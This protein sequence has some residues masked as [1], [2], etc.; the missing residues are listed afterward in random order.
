MKLHHMTRLMSAGLLAGALALGAAL[1]WP[2]WIWFL[3]PALAAGA[4]LADMRVSSAEGGS[5]PFPEEDE[6][7]AAEPPPEAPYSDTS[8]VVVPVQSAL[9]DCPFLFSATIWWREA[10]G[11]ISLPHGNPA[12][13]A[14]TSILQRVQHV[15][16]AEHPVRCTFL[17]HWLE[18]VLGTPTT[19][20]SGT[21]TSYATDVRLVLRQGDQEHLD[22][23]DGL[24]K[25]MGTWESRRQHE[26]NLR[27]YLGE[28]VL[29]SPGSAVVW[30]MAR[31]DDEI[32]RA[33]EMIAPL[34]VLS[35]AA[36]DQEI[37]DKFFDLFVSRDDSAGSEPAGGF[38]HPEPLDD[39]IPPREET[40]TRSEGYSP[41]PGERASALL[42]EM[43]FPQGS[44]ERAAFVHR[45]ARMSDEAGRSDAAE[46]I[47]RVLRREE[48][49]A[50]GSHEEWV[51]GSTSVPDAG[52]PP[53]SGDEASAAH[54]DS[55]HRAD[56]VGESRPGGWQVTPT[57]EVSEAETPDRSGSCDSVQ[58]RPEDGDEGVER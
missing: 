5:S 13:L 48:N 21:V 47:R 23:L 16:M 33:V 36:N 46:S 7:S 12:A 44:A 37:P 49:L 10:E 51:G 34:T 20:D 9:E 43:G 45:L 18:G 52:P 14:A 4:I 28:E 22:E 42:D 54:G 58:N 24:R 56:A 29:Q 50:A 1:D 55:V 3:L 19:D 11:A 39:E 41:P 30:W 2:I 25:A 27:A 57:G 38:G 26:R 15:T 32:E 31:H 35:A 8:V 40:R 53:P 17:G 6:E